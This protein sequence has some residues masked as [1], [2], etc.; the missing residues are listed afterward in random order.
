MEISS[1]RN[2]FFNINAILHLFSLKKVYI[3]L[4]LAKYSFY[5]PEIGL[6]EIADPA[7]VASFLIWISMSQQT[8]V[9]AGFQWHA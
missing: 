4:Q 1:D 7:G 9:R 6:T 2:I 8:K 5:K 3:S